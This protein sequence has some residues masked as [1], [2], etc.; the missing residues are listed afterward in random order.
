MNYDSETLADRIVRLL[1]PQLRNPERTK[2]ILA[3]LSSEAREQ[4]QPSDETTSR[5]REVANQQPHDVVRFQTPGQLQ[6]AELL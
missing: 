1:G 6:Q 5:R 2:E 3:R 4:P